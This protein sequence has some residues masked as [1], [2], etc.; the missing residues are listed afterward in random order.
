MLLV[1][2]MAWWRG[3]RALPATWPSPIWRARWSAGSWT[4]S[5]PGANSTTRKIEPRGGGGM[6]IVRA[7]RSPATVR[8]AGV[9]SVTQHRCMTLPVSW[10][11]TLVGA[12]PSCSTT[13]RPSASWPVTT[14]R[15]S[16]AMAPRPARRRT[17]SSRRD[18]PR[19]PQRGDHRGLEQM[20]IGERRV[21]GHAPPFGE[22]ARAH[23]GVTRLEQ[24]LVALGHGVDGVD[25]LGLAPR[26]VA[27][28]HAGVGAAVPHGGQAPGQ[29]HG[30][31]Q[32][33]GQ[34]PAA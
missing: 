24:A 7:P 16:L 1:R 5:V 3:G 22:I 13:A 2:C 6:P 32:P 31:V 18:H 19:A 25:G 10:R 28:E 33:A 8:S 29:I 17:L 34:P 20:L 11:T 14:R 23:L 9:S 26:L 21:G 30:V 27:V 4:L 15:M 12:G